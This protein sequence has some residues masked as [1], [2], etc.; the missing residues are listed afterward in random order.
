MSKENN[1]SKTRLS[2]SNRRKLSYAVF[3]VPFL[4]GFFLL[5]LGIYINSFWYSL[6]ELEMKGIGG[7]ALHYVGLENY[8]FA[9]ATDPTFV[10]NIRATVGAMLP[11]IIMAILYSLMIAVILNAKFKG[12]T[13]FRSIFFIPVILATG[14]MA[15]ADNL[16]AV[17]SQQWNS[18]AS[19]GTI[20]AVANGL[21]D[22]GDIRD[23]FMNLSFSPQ[24]AG[25]VIGAV[26]QIFNIVNISGVQMLI[27]LAGL[28]S[29]SPSIY[30][31]ADID[32]CSPWEKFWLITFPMI[33][34]IIVVNVIY[35]IVDT[36]TDSEN[37]IMTQIRQQNTTS[38]GIASAMA[39]FY[40][41]TI[42]ICIAVVTWVISR[43]V[44][45]QQK[46]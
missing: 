31:A 30:E 14:F 45:Y 15:R 7:F 21:I 19:D 17:F 41:A 5:F 29:I 37:I 28:Q 9:I 6:N 20:E 1:K 33:S 16:S 35:T 3:L 40:F 42:A 44:H 2:Y 24:L 32:G 11:N 18:M 25:F 23:F 46:D 27:F 36:F 13:V 39:W 4:A 34:P 38:M 43:Y 8:Q 22:T 10:S 26:D 12:R